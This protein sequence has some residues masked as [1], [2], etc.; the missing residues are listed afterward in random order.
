MTDIH[1]RVRAEVIKQLKFAGPEVTEDVLLHL[2]TVP[3]CDDDKTYVLA[4]VDVIR[5]AAER[6]LRPTIDRLTA[7]AALAKARADE[8]EAQFKRSMREFEEFR[9]M[10]THQTIQ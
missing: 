6:A 2:A 5:A 7:E 1:E 3:G 9:R 8:L 4:A 10:K